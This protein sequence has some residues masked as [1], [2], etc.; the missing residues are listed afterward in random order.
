[1]YA[2]VI[3]L[4]QFTVNAIKL[5]LNRILQTKYNNT[6]NQVL[7]LATDRPVRKSSKIERKFRDTGHDKLIAPKGSSKIDQNV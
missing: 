6:I 1:M 2:Q 3:I 7:R 5:E 4:C